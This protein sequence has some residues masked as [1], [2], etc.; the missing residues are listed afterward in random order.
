MPNYGYRC[1]SCSYGFEEQRAVGEAEPIEPCP[2]CGGEGRRVFQL[3]GIGFKGTGFDSTDHPRGLV[4]KT[5]PR[6]TRN[7]PGY[8][9]NKVYAP[10][11]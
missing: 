4:N 9:P 7:A 8:D 11:E 10:G 2:Q 3:A 1:S 5:Y 6:I